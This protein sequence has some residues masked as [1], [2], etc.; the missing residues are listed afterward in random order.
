MSSSFVFL[1]V[2]GEHLL[3][4]SLVDHH[5][6]VSNERSYHKICRIS[7]RICQENGLAT[8][9]PTKK[10]ELQKKQ[11]TLDIIR[12]NFTALL[13]APEISSDLLPAKREPVS[14]TRDK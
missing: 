8:S 3:H 6:Y 2:S 12:Q 9:M 10:K 4:N 14:V 7:N 11:K 1:K 5:K 13:D